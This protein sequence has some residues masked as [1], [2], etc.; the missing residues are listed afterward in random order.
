[1]RV[2]H[3]TYEIRDNL[4]FAQAPDLNDLMRRKPFHLR[5][6]ADKLFQYIVYVKNLIKEMKYFNH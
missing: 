4:L 6:F 1:M 5:L 3:E 2:T